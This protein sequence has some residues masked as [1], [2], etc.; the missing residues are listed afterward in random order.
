MNYTLSG[1]L[2]SATATEQKTDTFRIRKFV[3][4]VTENAN[5]QSY[6]NFAEF[7]LVNNNCDIL[8]N[9]QRGQNVTVHFNVRG[10]IWTNPQGVDKCITNLNAW[11]IEPVQIQQPTPQQFA[12]QQA[13]GQ[14]QP[15]P[16]PQPQQGWGQPAQQNRNTVP[17][18]TPQ[19]AWGNSY[20]PQQDV[21]DDLPF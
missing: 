20:Q 9:F 7:Q 15:Q 16:Q 14:P 3:L 4:E 5:G 17:A 1:R 19:Q 8:N 12:P 10:Q 13:W 21:Q 2:H 6:T 18:Q 11:K